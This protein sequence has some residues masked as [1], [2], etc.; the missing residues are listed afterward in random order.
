L[1]EVELVCDRVVILTQ[2]RIV[3]EGA[4]QDLVTARGVEIDTAT[5]TKV[6]DDALREDVPRLVAELVAEGEQIYGVRVRRPTLEDFYIDTVGED[7]R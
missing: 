2:G 3:A 5:G 6:F 1:S 4:P 7:V